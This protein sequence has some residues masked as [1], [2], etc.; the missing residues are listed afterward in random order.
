MI[1]AAPNTPTVYTW[2]YANRNIQI[3]NDAAIKAAKISKATTAPK[4][5]TLH[6]TP[7]G[8]FTGKMESCQS[9]LNIPQRKVTDDEYLDSLAALMKKYNEV[10]ITS[11]GERSSNAEGFRDYQ[12]LKTQGRLPILAGGTGLYLR[13]LLDGIAP[14]PDIDPEIRTQI[15]HAPVEDNR[16]RLEALDPE[17]AERLDPRDR[18]R[19][20]RALEVV[21]STGRTLKSWQSSRA[22]GIKDGAF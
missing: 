14:V 21:L 12:K 20:A 17:A 15:R 16:R 7:N 13:T 19:T 4:G 5:C 8:E 9:L 22:G 11:I 6:F 1:V 3:L 18:T 10:G 2:Q